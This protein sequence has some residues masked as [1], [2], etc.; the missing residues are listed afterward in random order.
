MSACYCYEGLIAEFKTENDAI[1]VIGS[2]VVLDKLDSSKYSTNTNNANKAEEKRYAECGN[3]RRRQAV[4]WIR[5][6]EKIAK[7]H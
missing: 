3:R 2:V 6:T 5:K 4:A 7:R 1:V